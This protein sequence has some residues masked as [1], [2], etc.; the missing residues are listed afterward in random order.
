[1]VLETDADKLTRETG[2]L[3]QEAVSALYST[4]DYN[5]AKKMI[6]NNLK[7]RTNESINKQRL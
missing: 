7:L 5:E 4:L 3:I 6:L 1:M 2:C